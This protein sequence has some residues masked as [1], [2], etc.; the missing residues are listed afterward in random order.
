MSLY[1][2]EY[3]RTKP[4]S[5][6]KVKRLEEIKNYLKKYKYLL[7]V[8][9]TNV[10]APVL[11][12]SRRLLK[13]DGSILKV[14]KNTLTR[15]AIEEVKKEKPGIEKIES[16]LKGQKAI[17]F[18]DKNPFEIQLFLN[19]NKIPRAAKAGDIA[20]R[21][22]VIPAGNTN[23]APGPILSMFNKLK[24]PIKI[25]EGS[26]W[27]S[28][29]TVVAKAGETIT[30]DVADLL[31]KLGIKPI[32]V[33][34]NVHAIY[35]DGNV[36]KAEEINIDPEYYSELFATAVRE[37]INL[38]INSGYPTHETI[39][40]IVKKAHLEAVSLAAN[41][42]FITKDTA[43]QILGKLYREAF[44]LYELIKSKNPEVFQS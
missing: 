42:V 21:D 41:V 14:I 27:V 9:I 34:L 24:I 33:G 44:S 6:V 29:D 37:A 5:P 39:E 35:L 13:K 16:F 8:D 28:K 19:K 11:H 2:V 43:E 4:V 10:T 1:K 38:S 31:G 18:T 22:I 12:E 20:T 36:I 23:F 15:F 17:I 32:E 3:K 7:L 25:Q 30:A 26:I 40:D